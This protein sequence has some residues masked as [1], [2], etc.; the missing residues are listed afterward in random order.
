M[1]PFLG[2]FWLPDITQKA[3]FGHTEKVLHGLA[4]Q[5]K[6]PV[7]KKKSRLNGLRLAELTREAFVIEIFG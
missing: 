6:A 7:V 5:W 2:I 3:K 4:V 1:A